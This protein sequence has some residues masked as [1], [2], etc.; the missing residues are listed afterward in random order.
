M[1]RSS[2]IDLSGQATYR[3]GNVTNRTDLSNEVALVTGEAETSV[4]RSPRPCGVP[5]HVSVSGG[6]PMLARWNR[7]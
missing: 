7:R 1:F 3:T 5:V 6:A 4:S 2:E